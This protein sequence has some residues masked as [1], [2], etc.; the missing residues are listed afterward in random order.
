M[1]SPSPAIPSLSSLSLT[2]SLTYLLLSL[3]GTPRLGIDAGAIT[4]HLLTTVSRSQEL[5]YLVSCSPSPSLLRMHTSF[6]TNHLK[7]LSNPV[8]IRQ[9]R[10]G[11]TPHHPHHQN[12]TQDKGRKDKSK[13]QARAVTSTNHPTHQKPT[14]SVNK[15]IEPCIALLSVFCLSIRSSISF[16]FILSNY[17]YLSGSPRDP[18]ERASASWIFLAQKRRSLFRLIS[19]THYS[20]LSS[21]ARPACTEQQAREQ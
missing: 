4:A 7:Y 5:L 3:K 12:P 17:S 10:G 2:H 21:Y 16:L 18:K 11:I 9:A 13:K 19:L 6:N 15:R 14:Q 20:Q 8:P 1:T